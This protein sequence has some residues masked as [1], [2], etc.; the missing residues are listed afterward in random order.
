MKC[1]GYFFTSCTYMHMYRKNKLR[2]SVV[3]KVL[4]F[5]HRRPDHQSHDPLSEVPNRNSNSIHICNV[6][7]QRV[8][9][10]LTLYEDT[11]SSVI[12]QDRCNSITSEGAVC[13]SKHA[14]WWSD[15]VQVKLVH[16]N[17]AK[18][19]ASPLIYYWERPALYPREIHT[20]SIQSHHI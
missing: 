7:H 14:K 9:L 16:Y 10:A 6:I 8:L 15:V 13:S 1:R 19:W 12:D 2:I 20:I 17:Y 3:F 18:V 5:V 11:P 4:F